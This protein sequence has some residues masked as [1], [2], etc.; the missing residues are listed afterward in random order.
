M[1]K[2]SMQKTRW[3]EAL[4]GRPQPTKRCRLGMGGDILRPTEYDRSDKNNR[5][6]WQPSTGVW[7]IIKSVKSGARGLS[8]GDKNTTPV[9]A[10][11]V[12]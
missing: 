10:A 3:F 2:N 6:V 4:Y 12:R 1:V 11:F 5:A 9:P 8:S 7:Y